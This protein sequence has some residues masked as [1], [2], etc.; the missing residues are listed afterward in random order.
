MNSRTLAAPYIAYKALTEPLAPVNQGS[1]AALEVILPEGN[2]MM[3][4]YPALMSDWSSPLPTV[5]DTI[6]RALAPALPE[7]IPAAHSGR[8]GPE[9]IFYGDVDGRAFIAQGLE[10]GGWG[11]RPWADGE[12]VSVSVCQGDVR[13][14]P[15]EKIELQNPMRVEERAFAQD[16]GGAGYHRG[17][18]GVRLHT[19]ALVPGRWYVDGGNRTSCPPW[20]LWG[21]RPG[22]PSTTRVKLPGYDSFEPRTRPEMLP[23]QAGTEIILT[24]AG[25]GGWGRPCEREPERVLADVREGLVSRGCA[26]S[27]YGV[28]LDTSGAAIDVAATAARRA[29]LEAENRS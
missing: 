29:Q 3:A 9:L 7:E 2:M 23:V 17:G 22:A 13:N 25:G 10:G 20:G 8:L 14:A 28:V 27:E 4:H 21:G 6:L 11:G 24:S 19:R 18:L 16:S 26:E 5:V 15:I 1:F 12:S